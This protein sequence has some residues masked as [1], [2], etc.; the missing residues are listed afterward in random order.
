M[1]LA[2]TAAGEA[3]RDRILRLADQLFAEHGYPR[4]S[5][6]MVATAAGVTKPALYY[7]FRNKD[8]LFEECVLATQK[9]M[10]EMLADAAASG[11]TLEERLRPV[12][13]ILL[14]GS[15][16]HPVL[17]QNDIAEHLP[18]EVR[19]RLD[20]GFRATVFGPL[21]ALFAEASARGEMRPGVSDGVAATAMLGVCMAFLPG[22]PAGG[23]PPEGPAAEV[24][25]DVLLRGVASLRETTE[26]P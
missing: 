25:A 26:G 22:A 19:E 21:T 24:V 9:R 16:H 2:V 23:A 13:H 5:M 10:G 1:S 17:I 7:H 11:A 8:A 14:T 20:E 15:P 12:A 3:T 18:P 6:R 4:V